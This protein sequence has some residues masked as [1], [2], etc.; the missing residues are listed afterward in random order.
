LNGDSRIRG[1]HHLPV[2]RGVMKVESFR[3]EEKLQVIRQKDSGQAS[4]KSQE[5]NQQF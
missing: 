3:E 4:H 2:L 1:C 5:T